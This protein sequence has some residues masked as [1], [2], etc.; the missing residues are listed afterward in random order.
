M[1]KVLHYELDGA[2]IGCRCAHPDL[3]AVP[4]F[5]EE[6]VIVSAASVLDLTEA[7]KKPILVFSAGCSYRD[8]L[9]QWLQAS[10]L[11]QSVIM[12]FGTLE[13]IIGGVSAGLGI[14]LMPRSV[15]QKHAAEGAVRLH[16]MPASLRES[17]TTFITRKDAFASSALKAFMDR[18]PRR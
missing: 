11:P 5:I 12:E 4:A 7:V 17:E 1:D 9:E 8:V 6:L 10:G 15:V 18:L 14:S 13:A 2:F 16:E 3:Q